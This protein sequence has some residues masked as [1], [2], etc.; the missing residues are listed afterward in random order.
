MTAAAVSSSDL[1]SAWSS[2]SAQ[3]AI[4]A[5]ARVVAVDDLLG[6]VGDLIG[7]RPGVV[8]LPLPETEQVR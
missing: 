5:S 1:P 8:R 6:R 3:L 7:V 2:G 4:N